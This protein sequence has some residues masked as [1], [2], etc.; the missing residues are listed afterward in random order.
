MIGSRFGTDRSRA[1]TPVAGLFPG[2]RLAGSSALPL[3]RCSAMTGD[4]A[5]IP[6]EYLW[7]RCGAIRWRPCVRCDENERGGTSEKIKAVKIIYLSI[8][9]SIY[10]LIVYLSNI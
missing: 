9:L 1:I 3:A 8:Y 6:R 5:A 4:A 2:A 10:H 7:Y